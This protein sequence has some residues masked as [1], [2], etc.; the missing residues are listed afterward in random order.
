MSELIQLQSSLSRIFREALPVSTS[1][2][3]LQSIKALQRISQELDG[4]SPALS[5]TSVAQEVEAY[6]HRQRIAGFR[7]LKYV[8]H[9][10]AMQ[11]Q[12]GWCVLGNEK[13]RD[14]L[15]ADVER[16]VKFSRR[17]KCFEALLRSYFSFPR[18]DEQTPKAAHAGWKILRD[19]LARQRTQFQRDGANKKIRLPGWFAV[20][21]EHENLL[22][23]SPCN[24]YGEDM[25]RG[26][27]SSIEEARRGLGIPSESWVMQEAI[28]SQMRAAV[29]LGEDPFKA[30]LDPLLRLAQGQTE[31]KVSD[32]LKRRAIALLI[33]RYANCVSKSE[34]PALRDAAVTAIG[35]PWL[36]RTAWD[37]WVKKYDG[38][39]DSESREMVNGWLTRQLITDFFELLSADGKAV[40][41]RIDYWLKYESQIEGLWFVLGPNAWGRD[42]YDPRYKAVRNR[43]DASQWLEMSHATNKDNNAFVMRIGDKLVI[44]FGLTGNA[45][46]F[47]AAEPMPFVLATGIGEEQSYYSVFIARK[48]DDSGWFPDNIVCGFSFV[49]EGETELVDFPL[50]EAGLKKFQ[51][52]C[53]QAK[54]EGLASFDYPGCPKPIPVAE[55]EQMISIIG[56]TQQEVGVG[57]M[58]KVARDRKPR[59]GLI[60]KPNIVKVDYEERRGVLAMPTGRQAK[61]PGSLKDGIELKVHQFS[62]VA[63]LQHLWS[64][65]PHECR[66]A[67]LADDMGLGKTLQLLT[68]IAACL[69]E[70]PAVDPFL[71]VAPVSLLENWQEEMEKFFKPGTFPLLTLYGSELIGGAQRI[72]LNLPQAD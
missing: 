19:W 46:F 52:E 18:Y 33:S 24:R 6:R 65:S 9:G 37:A 15:L 21:T 7:D 25:L 26:N 45:C 23:D 63:W 10:A 71:I 39:P 40:Q 8:C 49:P 47:Y 54:S 27:N 14:E 2:E 68:F 53:E 29:A 62:G 11:M 20:L 32:L 66:G 56:E 58:P 35:N 17:L 55:A 42:A 48:N 67:L 51:R 70:S 69:E 72:R 12:D 34:H 50:T 44:E 3:S 1:L 60:L 61:L 43:S 41:R 38:K 5:S 4:V 28:L 64:L 36:K 13:L 22:T 57:K 31:V 16:L 59:T 30:R